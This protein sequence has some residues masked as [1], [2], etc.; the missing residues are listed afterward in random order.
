[1]IASLFVAGNL[2]M[3]SSLFQNYSELE[4]GLSA[5]QLQLH[6]VEL[7]FAQRKLWTTRDGWLNEKQ[8]KLTNRDQAPVMLL[9]EIEKTTKGHDVLVLPE[10]PLLSSTVE[11]QPTY[12]AVWVKV[13]TEGTLPNL[14][15]FLNSLQQPD[16]FIVFKEASLEVD[17]ND[18]TK[19]L[20]T[21][22]I[23]KWYKR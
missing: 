9:N 21:F 6:N 16:R 17:P 4:Q 19:M 2:I 10:S 8:P 3:L 11:I 13:K 23:A 18:A 14:V 22:T 12:Q 1:M 5:K 20:G 15:G 7:M